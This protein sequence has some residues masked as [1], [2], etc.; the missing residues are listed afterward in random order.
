MYA[1]L[2]S[3]S[4]LLN[5]PLAFVVLY[6]GY[7]LYNRV[8]EQHQRRFEAKLRE[9]TS[10][11]PSPDQLVRTL[12]EKR[13]SSGGHDIG[14]ADWRELVNCE[15]LEKSWDDFS[16][17]VTKD[18]VTE[19]FYAYITP[20]DELPENIVRALQNILGEL[21]LRTRHVNIASLL[22]KDFIA[23]LEE[24][25]EQY[26]VTSQSVGN[27]EWGGMTDEAQE[28]AY[29]AH[30]LDT[31]ALHPAAKNSSDVEYRNLQMI[32]QGLVMKLIPEKDSSCSAMRLFSTTR[33][34]RRFQKNFH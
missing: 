13:K 23:M 6:V 25:I 28:S 16:R 18:F 15:E 10:R 29:E 12:K 19:L 17:L 11:F 20:D 5:I 1:V 7:A 27:R 4:V 31:G 8:V 3:R 32:S 24:H 33:P 14:D 26:R 34:M 2:A 9:F 21:S 30:L 22:L